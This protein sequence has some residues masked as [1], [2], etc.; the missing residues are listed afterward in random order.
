M[1]RSRNIRAYPRPLTLSSDI[2]HDL[3]AGIDY[4]LLIFFIFG[5]LSNMIAN[6]GALIHILAVRNS[7]NPVDLSFGQ[8]R[9]SERAFTQ[10]IQPVAGSKIPGMLPP[11]LIDW[12]RN[13]GIS[14]A[15]ASS[16][17]YANDTAIY[18]A[19]DSLETLPELIW[20]KCPKITTEENKEVAVW[21]VTLE[22]LISRD[23]KPIK[24]EIITEIPANSKIGEKASE[25]VMNAVFIPAIKDGNPVRCWIQLPLKSI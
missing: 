25:A 18:S 9:D 4:A 23:G 1:S 3:C 8:V 2:R 19:G 6:Q 20:M 7:A 22:I 14:Q 13:S 17:S 11:L 24:T 10:N 5:W 12:N 21:E 16:P 15:P